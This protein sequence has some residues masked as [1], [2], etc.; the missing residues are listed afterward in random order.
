[1]E[2][3]KLGVSACLL[4]LKVR[5]DGGHK[6]DRFL[7][8]TLGRWVEFLPVCPELECGLGVPREASRLVGDPKAPRFVT[9]RTGQDLTEPLAAWAG[10]RVRELEAENLSGYIFKSNSSSCAMAWRR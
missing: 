8:G 6:R 4:G 5:Y 2:K 10:K 3:I 9:V 1:M 7:T